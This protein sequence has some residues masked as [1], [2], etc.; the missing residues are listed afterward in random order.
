MKH[1][2]LGNTE[3]IYSHY[4]HKRGPRIYGNSAAFRVCGVSDDLEARRGLL[5]RPSLIIGLLTIIDDLIEDAVA[6]NNLS[7]E[8]ALHCLYSQLITACQDAGFQTPIALRHISDLDKPQE[9]EQSVN[10]KYGPPHPQI[11]VPGYTDGDILAAVLND[12][13]NGRSRRVTEIMEELGMRSGHI[14]PHLRPTF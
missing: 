9:Q 11:E 8:R 10:D 5:I 1:S 2:D 12:L 4:D 7:R 3:E 13:S 14:D 6:K